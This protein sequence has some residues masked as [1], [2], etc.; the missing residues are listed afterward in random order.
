MNNLPPK[1]VYQEDETP[2][3]LGEAY[4]PVGKAHFQSNDF[5]NDESNVEEVKSLLLLLITI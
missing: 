2:N 5:L 4:R 3:M 1:S